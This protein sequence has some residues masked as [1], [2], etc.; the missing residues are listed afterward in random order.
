[1]PAFSAVLILVDLLVQLRAI[2]K[3]DLL[4]TQWSRTAAS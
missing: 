3:S 1:M 2:R 4:S